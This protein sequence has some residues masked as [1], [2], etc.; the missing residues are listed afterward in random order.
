MYRKVQPEIE[1]GSRASVKDE[2]HTVLLNYLSIVLV[3]LNILHLI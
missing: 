2:S 3:A 1:E